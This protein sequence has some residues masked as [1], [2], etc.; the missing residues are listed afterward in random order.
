MIK[1]ITSTGT[2]VQLNVLGHDLNIVKHSDVLSV[3][4]WDGGEL[5]KPLGDRAERLAFFEIET[6]EVD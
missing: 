5:E 3:G 6:Y 1:I 2:H 4:I